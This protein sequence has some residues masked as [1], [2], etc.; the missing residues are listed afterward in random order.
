VSKIGLAFV[1][2][3]GRVAHV[4][5]ITLAR[6]ASAEHGAGDGNLIVERLTCG[7]FFW[8]K[9]IRQIFTALSA[10]SRIGKQRR[11]LVC[12][13]EDD[14]MIPGFVLPALDAATEKLTFGDPW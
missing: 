8:Q 9:S 14:P 6:E 3:G 10:A 11:C 13:G 4:A 1:G 12:G 5:S 7:H 2:C